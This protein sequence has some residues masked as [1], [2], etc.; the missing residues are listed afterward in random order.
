MRHHTLRQVSSPIR[1]LHTPGGMGPHIPLG[2]APVPGATASWMHCDAKG[3]ECLAP[4][5]FAWGPRPCHHTAGSCPFGFGALCLPCNQ[6]V[7]ALVWAQ[8]SPAPAWPRAGLYGSGTGLL[9]I[10]PATPLIPQQGAQA[11]QPSGLSWAG[12]EPSARS[13]LPGHWQP[14]CCPGA[15]LP[16]AHIPWSPY[17]PTC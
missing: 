12:T 1:M 5:Q 14:S 16:P 8:V 9:Q 17:F 11:T 3:R 6:A 10:I 15:W 2:Q 13:V 4:R 7:G